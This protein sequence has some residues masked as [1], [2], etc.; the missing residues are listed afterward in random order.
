MEEFVTRISAFSEKS[1][2]DFITFLNSVAMVDPRPM[3]DQRK[4]QV[5]CAI[6]GH[7]DY[8]NP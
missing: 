8:V 2:V 4:C 3:I 1:T 5:G 6:G 7:F